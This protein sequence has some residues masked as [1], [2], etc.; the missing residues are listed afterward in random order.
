MSLAAWSWHLTFV[1]HQMVSPA[2]VFLRGH[3]LSIISLER[4]VLV[5]SLVIALFLIS[6]R[7][8]LALRMLLTATVALVVMES[9]PRW[10]R[11]FYTASQQFG[12]GKRHNNH[13]E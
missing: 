9:S 13:L 2:C 8:S 4:A 6:A 12:I 3:L 1:E 5:G 7:R 10:G 11:L